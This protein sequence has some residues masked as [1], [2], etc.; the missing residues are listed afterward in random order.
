MA[1]STVKKHQTLQRR[2]GHELDIIYRKKASQLIA[3]DIGGSSSSSTHS[4]V[5][6]DIPILP[7]WKLGQMEC[8]LMKSVS[9]E[10]ELAMLNEST[11]SLEN[12]R[13][14]QMSNLGTLCHEQ[15]KKLQ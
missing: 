13:Q 6:Q 15:E 14:Q 1:A 10:E 9:P 12:P 5:N 7:L 2:P 11:E 3:E 4:H 8:T